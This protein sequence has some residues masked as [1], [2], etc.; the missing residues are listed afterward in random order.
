M[1]QAVA[2]LAGRGAHE[3]RWLAGEARRLIAVRGCVAVLARLLIGNAQSETVR[4]HR[5][6]AHRTGEAAVVRRDAADA[7]RSPHAFLGDVARLVHRDVADEQVRAEGEHLGDV[8]QR[9]D[10]LG[11]YHHRGG[12]GTFA[13]RLHARIGDG[14]IDADAAQIDRAVDR[15]QLLAHRHG[16][17]GDAVRFGAVTATR[18][19]RELEWRTAVQLVRAEPSRKLL[20]QVGTGRGVV[21]GQRREQPGQKKR[22]FESR[23]HRRLRPRARRA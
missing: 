5:G 3:L 9:A 7:A 18:H 21:A 19:R 8:R 17:V 23:P 14:R 15:P 2:H 6:R 12:A 16:R 4:R 10:A 20:G 1:T 13:K 22:Q 11:N